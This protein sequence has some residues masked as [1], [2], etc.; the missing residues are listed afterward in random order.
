MHTSLLKGEFRQAKL[1]TLAAMMLLTWAQFLV[2]FVP[3]GRWRHSLGFPATPADRQ[4]DLHRARGFAADVGWA[5]RKLPWTA[6]CLSRAMA[7]SW[8]MRRR[9]IGHSVVIAVRPGDSRNSTDSLHAWVEMA[10][11]KILG[12]LPGPWIEALRL[13]EQTQPIT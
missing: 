8:M 7:L 11:K 3:F 1:R 10:D 12:D 2:V 9:E 5:A 4:I 6:K 13:G